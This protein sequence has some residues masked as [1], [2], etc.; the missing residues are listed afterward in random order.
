MNRYT[1]IILIAFSCLVGCKKR[2]YVHDDSFSVYK[3]YL[4]SDTIPCDI[5]NLSNPLDSSFVCQ[6]NVL[7]LNS[8][9]FIQKKNIEIY[10]VSDILYRFLYKEYLKCS[11]EWYMNRFG[12]DGYRESDGY[13][14]PK[15]GGYYFCGRLSLHKSVQS[16]IFLKVFNI[17]HL[18]NSEL[19]LLNIKDKKIRSIIE[20]SQLEREEKEDDLSLKTYLINNVGFISVSSPFR[21]DITEYEWRLVKKDNKIDFER[22]N[23]NKKLEP[24]RYSNFEID[25]NGYALF[26]PTSI[27]T[28]NIELINKEGKIK[29]FYEM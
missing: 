16:L 24:F 17:D 11:A 8:F 28:N 21:N 29:P 7:H 22:S 18:N 10:K 2:E 15:N 27:K 1:F 25:D 4:T 26:R 13:R 19:I 14:L 6:D 9:Y 5:S 3:N 12:I 23:G 20:L